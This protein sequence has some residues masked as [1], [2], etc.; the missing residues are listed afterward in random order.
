MFNKLYEKIKTFFK[1]NY[2]FFIFLIF[3]IFIC[4]YEL[5]FVIYKSGGTIDLKERV[6]IEK[7]YEE[8]G[9]LKMSYVTAMKGT[10]PFILLSYIMPD[11]DLYPLKEITNEDSYEDVIEVGKE[12]MDEG[13]DN[14]IIAAF[15]RSDYKLTITKTHNKIIFISDEAKTD[16]VVGDEIVSINE[17]EI[18]SIE[19]LKT[20][21]NT[22]KEGEEVEVGVINTH[23]K[24]EVKKAQIY[25]DTDDTLKVG[26]AFHT[27]YEYETEI[28]VSIKMKDSESGSSGSF[29]MSL[30]IY[31]A[32]TE[33]DITK[34]LNIVGTGSI[35][36]DGVVEEIGGVKYKLLGAS[37]NKADIFFCPEENYEEALKVKKER[38][39]KIDVVKVHTLDDAINYLKNK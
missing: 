36:S 27:T 23:N 18:S 28:P 17:V 2:K 6:K 4:Y 31:N 5:P 39:L 34:G 14:A 19:K 33:E 12:Y 35:T 1:E 22:L 32:L 9:S 3:L 25:K 24:K 26:V 37:K 20:Y 21:I 11:W 8:S 16:L 30:Q 38:H 13:I 29:M 15:N 10:M 7:E